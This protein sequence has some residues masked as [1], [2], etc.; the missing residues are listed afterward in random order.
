MK[1]TYPQSIAEIIDQTLR[2]E[3]MQQRILEVRAAQAWPLVVG[4][5]IS[6]QTGKAF[7]RN[8]ILTVR[9]ASP[10]LRQELYMNRSSLIRHINETISASDVVKEI[11]FI[12]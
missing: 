10:A 5:M 9:V 7:V 3:D 11:R 4:E 1:R 6:R 12:S 8:G 2:Q